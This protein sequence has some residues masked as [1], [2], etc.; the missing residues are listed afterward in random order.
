MRC[1]KFASLFFVFLGF[2]ALIYLACVKPFL[3]PFILLYIAMAVL[4]LHRKLKK[5]VK[6]E[7]D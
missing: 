2:L 7:R 6:N 1:S 4:V 5:G 3:F